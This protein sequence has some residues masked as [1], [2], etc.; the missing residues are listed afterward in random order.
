MTLQE[1]TKQRIL[2]LCRQRGC[3]INRLALVCGMPPSS[4]KNII[5]GRSNS[6]TLMN[7]DKI[8][9]G[10][11]ISLQEFFNDPVFD[12]LEEPQ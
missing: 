7:V 4:L 3:T 5:Y 2:E 8:C 11:A 10:M 12:N 1:A 6:P 9:R